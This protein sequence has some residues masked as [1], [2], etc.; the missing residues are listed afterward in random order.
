MFT[1][2]YGFDITSNHAGFGTPVRHLP[3]R[4]HLFR[5]VYQR[6]TYQANAIK[7][8]QNASSSKKIEFYSFHSTHVQD[9]CV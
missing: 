9:D 8:L 7:L 2:K 5:S 4:T 1:N 6:Q 3:R